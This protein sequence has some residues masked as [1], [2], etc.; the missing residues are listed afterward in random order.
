MVFEIE[1]RI[2]SSKA[3][4]TPSHKASR[5][6]IWIPSPSAFLSGL[7]SVDTLT[8]DTSTLPT[9]VDLLNHTTNFLLFPSLTTLILEDVIDHDWD[10]ADLMRFLLRRRDA[11]VSITTLELLAWVQSRS[12]LLFLKG[13]DGLEVKWIEDEIDTKSEESSEEGSDE[14]T[15]DSM[16]LD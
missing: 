9:V 7:T 2:R 15:D 6:A 10:P 13:I 5:L 12:R 14:G 8:T 11:G 3:F 16:D 4:L 1:P